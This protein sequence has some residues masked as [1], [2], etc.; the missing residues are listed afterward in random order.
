M[1]THPEARRIVLD[2][3]DPA[4]IETRAI[5]LASGCVLREPVLADR[6]QPPFDRATMD[7]IAFSRRAWEAGQRTL[8][9]EAI[10][11]AGAPART[12]R[13]PERGCLRIMTGA[14]LPEGCD[15]ILEIEAVTLDGETAILSPGA[16]WQPG[17]HLHRQ[18]ADKKT[19][20]VLLGAGCV[21]TPPRLAIAVSAGA[22]TVRVSRLPA[23][24]MVSTGDELVE[25][26]RPAERY[27]VRPSNAH[28]LA[29][30]LAN[31]GCTHVARRHAPDDPGAIRERLA[32][33]VAESDLVLISGGVSMGLYDHVPDALAEVGVDC[34]F[35]R[36]AQ[37]PG[38]P[39]WFGR[40]PDGATVF[41]LPGN[42]VSSLIGFR[43]YVAPWLRRHLGLP[44]A[45]DMWVELDSAPPSAAPLTGFFPVRRR[46]SNV[47]PAAVECLPYHG[48]GHLASLADSDGY[49]VIAPDHRGRVAPF[50][51]W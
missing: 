41:G 43:E 27:Q 3:A 16:D 26:G 1:L 28:G 47:S 50:R 35:H 32:A 18:G 31:A 10:Q 13:D 40:H 38:K 8:R 20:Q 5:E 22:D 24:T 7:G 37:K 11:P 42:P 23:V 46:S 9:I 51:E 15:G 34:R 44:E 14:M 4:D 45:A 6:D 29:A 17:R 21:L 19:G 12:L 2:S 30:A 39:L 48:S 49:V 36:V 33:A 25:V